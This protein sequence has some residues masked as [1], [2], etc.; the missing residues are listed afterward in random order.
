MKKKTKELYDSMTPEEKEEMHRKQKRSWIRGEL[1][2]SDP[3]LSEKEAN[4][5]IDTFLPQLKD[6]N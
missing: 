6:N 5:R 1:M 4:N 3:N 2:L